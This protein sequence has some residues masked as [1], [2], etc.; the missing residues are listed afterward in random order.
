ME[1]M[2]IGDPVR[3]MRWS[4]WGILI[5]TLL[6]GSG[7]V[8][9]AWSSHSRVHDIAWTLIRGQG[10]LLIDAVRQGLHEADDP[11]SDEGTAKLLASLQ[12]QGVRYIALLPPSKNTEAGTALGGP[13]HAEFIAPGSEPEIHLT[14]VGSRIRLVLRA[15]PPPPGQQPPG[16]PPGAPPGPPPGNEFPPGPDPSRPGGSGSS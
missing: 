10:Q 2:R 14:E 4:R 6:M 9:S 13:P 12:D 7:M 3:L 16:P 5:T 1:F 11:G 15:P 8:L